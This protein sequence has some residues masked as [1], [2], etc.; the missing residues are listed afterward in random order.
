LC[1]VSSDALCDADHAA[2][3]LRHAHDGQANRVVLATA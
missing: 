3:A 2:S 1:R